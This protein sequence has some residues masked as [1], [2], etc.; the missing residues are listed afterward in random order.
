MLLNVYFPASRCQERLGFKEQFHNAVASRARALQAAGRRVVIAG[1]FNVTHRA[2]DHCS[3]E[4]WVKETGRKF[5]D[6]LFRRWM[7]ALLSPVAVAG[8]EVGPFVDC[9]RLHNPRAKGAFTWWDQRT[10]A[11]GNNYGTRLD[12]IVADRRLVASHHVH[13]CWIA[14]SIQGSD[15]CPVI[16]LIA[17][18]PV[19]SKCRPPPLAASR[20]TQHKLQVFFSTPRPD[21]AVRQTPA[22][23]ESKGGDAAQPQHATPVAGAAGSA[24]APLKRPAARLTSNTGVG[25]PSAPKRARQRS[26][27]AF[28]GGASTAAAPKRL[29][30]SHQRGSSVSARRP[31]VVRQAAVR[32]RPAPAGAGSAAKAV[33]ASLGWGKLLSGPVPPPRCKCGDKTVERRVIKDGPNLGT[34]PLRLRVQRCVP[35]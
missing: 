23:D 24:A 27:A 7:T 15:H 18:A 31:A 29:P 34:H 33:A 12:Y 14:P 28:F 4:A 13:A 16:A 22:R 6:H 21:D 1:D 8:T 2:I 35:H 5:E 32:V 3:P 26:I 11:R 19:P 20:A 9:F 25:R 10:G 30:A 17:A